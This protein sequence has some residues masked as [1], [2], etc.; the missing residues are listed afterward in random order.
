MPNH[1]A[2]W[3]LSTHP[4]ASIYKQIHFRLYNLALADGAALISA[5][6]ASICG[7]NA[8]AVCGRL[9]LSLLQVRISFRSS[10]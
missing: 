5:Y 10:T 2:P 4:L 6:M 8:L 1:S 7:L 9:S 3:L